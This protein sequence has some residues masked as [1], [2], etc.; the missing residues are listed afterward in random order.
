LL[1]DGYNIILDIYNY[2]NLAEILCVQTG[3]LI[4]ITS[5]TLKQH[6]EKTLHMGVSRFIGGYHRFSAV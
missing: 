5:Q 4:I 3:L 1:L 2:R 6:H